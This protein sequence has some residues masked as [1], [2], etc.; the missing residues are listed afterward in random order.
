MNMRAA[1]AST[2]LEF[3]GR[4][5]LRL[6]PPLVLLALAYMLV[7]PGDIGSAMLSLFYLTDYG[8]AFLVDAGPLSHTWSLAVE[9]HF[10]LLWPL[11]LL[12]LCRLP[13]RLLIPLL[14]AL[15]CVATAHR[16]GVFWTEGYDATYFR[17]DTRLSGLILGSLLAVLIRSDWNRDAVTLGGIALGLGIAGV[18]AFESGELSVTLGIAI[19][20]AAA[21]RVILTATEET[22][23]S[24]LTRFLALPALVYV[25]RISYGLY[26]FHHPLTWALNGTMH[27]TVVVAVALPISLAL[28]ALSY[29]LVERPILDR[30][31]KALRVKTAAN[32]P[33]LGATAAQPA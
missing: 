21:L 30:G 13:H 17:F 28:A 26:L 24:A 25:G 23:P 16:C 7:A 22:E 10:Y 6:T 32:T 5:F 1:A 8:R 27:W 20:E 9:E 18:F 4:R 3:Y 29:H 2:S 14:L 12:V 11:A 31:R 33:P 19:A 15:Y